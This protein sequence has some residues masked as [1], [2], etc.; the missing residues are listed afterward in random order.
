MK[1][2]AEIES[3]K[4]RVEVLEFKEAAKGERFI[5]GRCL[6][7][8]MMFPLEKQVVKWLSEDGESVVTDI[9]TLTPFSKVSFNGDY[10]EVR[11]IGTGRVTDAYRVK[12][13]ALVDMDVKVYNKA[14]YPD[15]KKNEKKVTMW[16]VGDR[17]RCIKAYENN[18]YAVGKEGVIV[19]TKQKGDITLL[20]VEF[21]CDIKGH[22]LDGKVR[23]SFGWW[24]DHPA[25]YLEHI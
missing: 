17:V 12:D 5:L 25:V 4:N 9:I 15:D 24:F 19:A 18:E 10:V 14:F 7:G 21:E 3:L 23:D 13:D 16:K 6:D 8:L 11:S 20:G 2:K 1:K 22:T